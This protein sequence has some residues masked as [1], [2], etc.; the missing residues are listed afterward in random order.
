MASRR[1]FDEVMKLVFMGRLKP[2]VDRVFPLEQARMAHEYLDRG[3]QFGKVV[4]AIS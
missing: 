4:L 1:E 2:V 3:E